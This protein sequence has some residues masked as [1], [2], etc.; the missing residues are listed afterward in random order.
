MQTFQLPFNV[1]VYGL[2]INSNNELL[3]SDEYCQSQYMTKFPGGGLEYGEGLIDGLKREFQEECFEEIEIIRHFYTTDFFQQ[4]MFRGG[5][6]LISVYYLCRFINEPQFPTVQIPYEGV[7][8]IN[9]SQAFRWI[10]VDQLNSDQVTW[11]IDKK[12]VEILLSEFN[13][14]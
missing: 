9:D 10:S 3:L 13:Q 6:Q 1:R 7:A 8:E 2:V 14:K 4:S 5:G 12:V 11:P